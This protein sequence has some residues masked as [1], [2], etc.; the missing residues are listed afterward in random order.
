VLEA[1]GQYDAGVLSAL[2]AAGSQVTRIN[3]RQARDFA[4]A[5]GQL[6]KTDALDAQM[7]ANLASVGN[8]LQLR[9]HQPKDAWQEDMAS[10]QQHRAH[11]QQGRSPWQPWRP[12]CLSWAN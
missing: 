7:L 9:T 3:P 6:A 2:H 12:T 4:K 11:L 1:T 8:A 5:S 10:Y